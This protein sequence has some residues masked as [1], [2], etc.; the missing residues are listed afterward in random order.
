VSDPGAWLTQQLVEFLAA[1]SSSPDERIA[2]RNALERAAEAFEAEVGAIELGG[3]IMAIVGLPA[4]NPV[5]AG[6]RSVLRDGA[7]EITV[8]G[9]GVCRTAIVPIEA[10][11]PGRMLLARSGEDGFGLEEMSLVRGMARVLGVTIAGLRALDRERTLRE[12]SERQIE[13]KAAILASLSERQK[14]LERLSTI[15]RS[16]SQR[17]ALDDVL[18]GVVEGAEA[19]IGDDVVGLRLIDPEDP[20]VMILAASRGVDERLISAMRR[21]KVGDGVGGRAIVEGRLVS[22]ED[23]QTAVGTIPE[24]VA[25]GLRSAMAAPV[26]EEGRI[27][28]SLVVASKTPGR[29]YSPTER[30]VLLSFAEHASIAITDAR[31]VEAKLHQAFHDSLTG[32]PNRALFLDRLE[33]A[34]EAR[35]RADRVAVMY[36]DVDRFKVVNDSL[37]HSAGDQLLIQIAQRVRSC[38]RADDLAARL[39]GDEFA[40]LVPSVKNYEDAGVLAGRVIEAMAKPFALA[41]KEIPVSASVGVSLSLSSDGAGDMLRD[42]DLA[43]Y[44]AKTA[45]GGHFRSFEQGMR[46]AVVDR[47]HLESDLRAALENGELRVEYQPII[48]LDHERITGFEAL[49]RWRHP[50]RGPIPPSTFIRLAEEAGMIAAVGRF[51][52]NEACNWACGWQSVAPGVGMNVNLSPKQFMDPTLISDVSKALARSGLA[53]HLLVLEITEN[54]L[55]EESEE[56]IARLAALKRLGVRL[57][58][59]DFGTGYSSLSYLR[60]FPVDILKVDRSFVEGVAEGPENAA[61]VNAIVSLAR[62][63]KLEVI[64]EGVE[65]LT[66]HDALRRMGCPLGQGFLYAPALSSHTAGA[67]LAGGLTSRVS[68]GPRAPAA[69]G[70][71]PYGGDGVT[72]VR[73]AP[74]RLRSGPQ[75]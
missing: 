31:T 4:R 64:A 75:A 10:T 6:L 52:L 2:I 35:T 54:V 74:V 71:A 7:G 56:S 13:E 12:Q 67:I 27:V 16:I 21:L 30:E 61:I 49:L 41:G 34:L 72:E 39:G 28:G 43:M 44:Q 58:I 59:D 3:E 37:G 63:L 66:Q 69:A 32:L 62:T 55:M 40:I 57:A 47:L 73:S 22:V 60:R 14:L 20:G 26:R 51:V 24:F 65:E 38:I 5:D 53:P 29:R 48:E 19:L 42:A 9:V 46:A 8:E 25:Q 17:A 23:Y 70:D 11:P 15:Q 18:D 50:V 1:V 33:E 36:I 68:A 45:G